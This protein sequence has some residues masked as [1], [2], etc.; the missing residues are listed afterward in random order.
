MRVCVVLYCISSGHVTA[1]VPCV[2]MCTV[3]TAV[4]YAGLGRLKGEAVAAAF[5][6]CERVFR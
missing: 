4:V 1:A 2:Q 3:F 6:F 5:L